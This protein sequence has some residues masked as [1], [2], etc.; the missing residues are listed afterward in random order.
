[1]PAW[2]IALVVGG[3]L[4]ISLFIASLAYQFFKYRRLYSRYQQVGGLPV[5][6]AGGRSAGAE[7]DT[8]EIAD[9]D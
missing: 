7:M 5:K 4:A 1:M 8:F 6:G 9:D 3:C 2:A